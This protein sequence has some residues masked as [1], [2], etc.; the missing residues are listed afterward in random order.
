M[1]VCVCDVKNVCLHV[2]V[3]AQGVRVELIRW[4][5]RTPRRPHDGYS[6]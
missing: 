1:C 3:H 5:C 6:L 2:A 4:S